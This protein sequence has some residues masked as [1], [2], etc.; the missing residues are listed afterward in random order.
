MRPNEGNVRLLRAKVQ[1]GEL[2]EDEAAAM[3]GG[4]SVR[5]AQGK[6][7]SWPTPRRTDYKNGRGKTGNRTEEARKKAGWTLPETV[8]RGQ[9][10]PTWVEWLMG[11]PLGWT[12]LDV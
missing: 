11:F 1:A 10:N 5:E 8:G 2:G 9:L 7:K 12:D 4:K 6:V 3:L